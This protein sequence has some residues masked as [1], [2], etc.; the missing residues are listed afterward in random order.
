MRYLPAR[1]FLSRPRIHSDDRHRQDRWPRPPP[2]P[3]HCRHQ[4]RAERQRRVQHD[5]GAGG[6]RLPAGGAAHQRSAQPGRAGEPVQCHL[7]RRGRGS[8]RLL[9]RLCPARDADPRAAGGARGG[10]SAS[11]RA[12]CRRPVPRLALLHDLPR[13]SGGRVH[14]RHRLRRHGP[15]QSRVRRRAG[16]ARRVR[17]GGRLPGDLGQHPGGRDRGAG[18][19][20]AGVRRARARGRA[21]GG[22]VGSDAGHDDPRRGRT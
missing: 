13:P 5:L 21:C 8:G 2:L 19:R 1:R 18:R 22:A 16:R 14:E 4:P 6:R 3:D 11:G 20:V 12:R 9:R 10:R 7:L 15:R 17:A